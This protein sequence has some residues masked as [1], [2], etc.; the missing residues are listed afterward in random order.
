MPPFHTTIAS[1]ALLLGLAAAPAGAATL[2]PGDSIAMTGT[3]YADHPELAGPVV[4]DAVLTGDNVGVPS[5]PFL[6]ARFDV[7]N[8]VVESATTGGLV[9]APR[10][11]FGSNVTGGNLLVDRVE[12]FGFGDFAVDASYRTDGPGDRGPTTASRSADGDTLAFDFG[13]PLV[14]SNLFAGP[15]EESYFLALRTEATAFDNTGR[16]SLF[17]RAAG[18]DF[19]TYRFDLG[20][21]AVPMAP[22]PLPATLPLLLGAFGLLIGWRHRAG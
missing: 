14:V 19:E 22:V 13:F 15:H 2:A 21:L 9:F 16:V 6:F 4:Q 11:L 20:G 18:D 7:S 10:I 12:L 1:A 3:T 8:V 17:A 5:L